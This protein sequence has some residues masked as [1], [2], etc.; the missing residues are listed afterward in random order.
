VEMTDA[1]LL[2][3]DRVAGNVKS[4]DRVVA[5]VSVVKI[6]GV[7]AALSNGDG[8]LDAGISVA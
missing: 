7:D 8:V 4:G 5:G 6:P 3:A 2:R 1:F